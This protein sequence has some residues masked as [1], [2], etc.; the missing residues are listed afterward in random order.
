MILRS[1]R[2]SLDS[3]SVFELGRD[4][5]PRS[6]HE[7]IRSDK[8][9]Q[10]AGAA[11]VWRADGVKRPFMEIFISTWVLLVVGLMLLLPMIYLRVTDYT[12]KET[13]TRTNKDS[14]DA[15]RA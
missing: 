2:M 4:D 14:E 13:L 6:E 9:L 15:V 3:V 12:K 7:K 10:S 5:S 1:S 8:S 11:G